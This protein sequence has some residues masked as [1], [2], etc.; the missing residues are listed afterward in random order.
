M[1]KSLI[2]GTKEDKI[3]VC[4]RI[5][6]NAIR[7][8]EYSTVC[9]DKEINEAIQPRHIVTFNHPSIMEK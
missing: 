6:A 2:M 3:A 4:H 5:I 1:R 8:I 7:D 9:K